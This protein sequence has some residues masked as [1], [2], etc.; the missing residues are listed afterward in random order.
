MTQ[1]E[2]ANRF[3]HQRDIPAMEQVI[4]QMVEE[5][6]IRLLPLKIK[7][8]A[9]DLLRLLKDERFFDTQTVNG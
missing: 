2:K 9:S 3:Y 6:K 5:M 7:E 4:S 1:I 8:K